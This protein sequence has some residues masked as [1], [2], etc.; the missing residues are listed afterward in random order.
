MH[1]V[2]LICRDDGWPAG[3][4]APAGAAAT[5][6]G[7]S[8][9]RLVGTTMRLTATA[10]S[11]RAPLTACLRTPG[12]SWCCT[13]SPHI[14]C[15]R[16]SHQHWALKQDV[17]VRLQGV[18]L[19]TCSTA[20]GDCRSRETT[21]NFCAELE[22]RH[23]RLKE[24]GGQVQRPAL[25]R[26]QRQSVERGLVLEAVL[27]TEWGTERVNEWEQSG[28]CGGKSGG[29][30]GV[31]CGAERC[32]GGAGRHAGQ[33]RSSQR[34]ADRVDEWRGE[35]WRVGRGGVGREGAAGGG[36]GKCG[37]WAEAFL[38][39][40]VI[41]G[42]VF[43]ACRP[44]RAG[45]GQVLAPRTRP[46]AEGERSLAESDCV[47]LRIGKDDPCGLPE[48]SRMRRYQLN[49]RVKIYPRYSSLTRRNQR[50]LFA[51]CFQVVGMWERGEYSVTVNHQ[52]SKH[53]KTC[54]TRVAPSI[55]SKL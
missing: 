33:G 27:E 13:G 3:L 18:A 26:P 21:R 29:R 19:A 49:S 25:R 39:L 32:E 5:G 48:G 44:R 17:P 28:G 20:L 36:E 11:W 53:Y 1:R 16:S 51:R 7:A 23:R 54:P 45:E 38:A 34:S 2:R 31:R 12:P 55:V 40:R 46:R 10:T 9:A 47:W 43:A 6:G 30:S 14:V 4:A 8:A 41:A 52:C 22:E 15:T 50:Y 42:A 35:A 24:P 37:A